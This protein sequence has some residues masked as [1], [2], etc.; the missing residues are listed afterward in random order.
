MVLEISWEVS[1][2][3]VGKSRPQGLIVNVEDYMD[4][5]EWENLSEDEKRDEIDNWVYEDFSDKV[6]YSIGDVNEV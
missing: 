2:G 3:Y 4:I 6:T 1:D 5:E